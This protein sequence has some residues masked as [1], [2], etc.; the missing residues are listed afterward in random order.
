ML[1]WRKLIGSAG[2][3]NEWEIIDLASGFTPISWSQKYVFLLRL[4][5]YVS[6]LAIVDFRQNFVK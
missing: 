6:I 2:T 5:A 4:W 1:F 3:V